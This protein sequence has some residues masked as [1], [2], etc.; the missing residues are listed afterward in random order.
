MK[1][2]VEKDVSVYPVTLDDFNE[3]VQANRDRIL[4]AVNFLIIIGTLTL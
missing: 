4:N 2:F 3:V 1:S